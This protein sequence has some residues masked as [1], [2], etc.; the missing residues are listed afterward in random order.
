MKKLALLFILLFSVS[1]A[2]AITIRDNSNKAI[3]SLKLSSGTTYNIYDAK[4]NK[5]GTYK[6]TAKLTKANMKGK[7]FKLIKKS[8]GT[9]TIKE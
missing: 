5:I 2:S 6:A 9:Y 4:G 8:D 1:I 3:G 7:K